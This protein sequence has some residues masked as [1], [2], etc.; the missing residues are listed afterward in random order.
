MRSSRRREKFNHGDGYEE[1]LKI[2]KLIVEVEAYCGGGRDNYK[3][4]N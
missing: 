2:L 3:I 4:L 1:G